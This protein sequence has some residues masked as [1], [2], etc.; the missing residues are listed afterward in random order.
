MLEFIRANQIIARGH[1]IFWE[2]PKYTP[3][4]VRDLTELNKNQLSNEQVQ[5]RIHTL[6]C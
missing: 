1:N 3:Q 4:W 6:G 5:R 2:D